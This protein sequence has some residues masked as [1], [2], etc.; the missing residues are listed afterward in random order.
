MQLQD[1][2]NIL[3]QRLSPKRYRH[4]YA[5]SQTAVELAKRF[6]ADPIQAEVAGLLHDYA[7]EMKSE[8][9]LQKAEAFGIVITAADRKTPALLHAPLAAILVQRE[10]EITDSAVCRAIAAHTT[11]L[12]HMSV[13]DKIIYL[14]DCIEPNRKYPGVEDLRKAVERGLNEAVMAA[15]NHSL[16]HLIQSN[17]WIHENTI[18]ARND[19]LEEMEESHFG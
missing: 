10:L 15:F 5:V 16:V 7:R 11:G 3:Q 4:T 6:G 18:A 19:L 12:Q 17:A 14:A 13:L 8:E 9:L 2:Q 1:Y